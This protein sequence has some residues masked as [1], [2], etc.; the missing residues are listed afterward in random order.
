[1]NHNILVIGSLTAIGA[2]LV[3]ISWQHK[4]TAA[5]L[6]AQNAV[7]TASAYAIYGQNIETTNIPTGGQLPITEIPQDSSAPVVQTNALIIAA[8]KTIAGS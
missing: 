4:Q 3:Y 5:A 6:T 7:D 1:M 8:G 2:A